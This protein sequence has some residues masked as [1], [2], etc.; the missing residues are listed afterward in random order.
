MRFHKRVRLWLDAPF[1]PSVA[2]STNERNHRFLEEALELVQS[3][4][5]E[6]VWAHRLVD[7]V[8]DRDAGQPFQELGGVLVTL[9]ALADHH[10]MD[11]ED[12]AEIE[13]ARCWSNIEKIRAKQRV[14]PSSSA[15][16]SPA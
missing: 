14:K 3:L 2:W 6:R 8:Y 11:A 10:G 13:L 12:A 15:T 16:P 7:Y 4:G 1:A 5:L 9:H